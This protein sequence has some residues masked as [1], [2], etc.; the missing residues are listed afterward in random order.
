MMHQGKF[1]WT[2]IIGCAFIVF[3]FAALP[4]ACRAKKAGPAPGVEPMTLDEVK[5][6]FGVANDYASGA[7]DLT[8][9][10]TEV[11]V[12][13]R[14]YD[15]D[16]QNYEADFSAEVAPK[17]QAFFRKFKTV[18]NLHLQVMANDASTP[19]LW[20]PFSEFTLDRKT[21]EKIQWTGLLAKYIEE[22][23]L[24]TKKE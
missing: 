7:V 10:A 11:I 12:A 2:G 19:G 17:V 15:V 4:A 21:V 24:K 14:Y 9:G 20:K 3:L 8:N 22:Q 1:L 6:V 13:Y 5:T 18:D 23:V 16:L